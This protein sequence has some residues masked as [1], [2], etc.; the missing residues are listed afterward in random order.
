MTIYRILERPG[1]VYPGAEGDTMTLT[2]MPHVDTTKPLLEAFAAYQASKM[3]S[4]TTIKNRASILRSLRSTVGKPLDQMQLPDLRAFLG[5]PG[6][7]ASSRRTER[8]AI[9]TFYG[10]L[11]DDGYRDD[12]PAIRIAPIKVPRS[13]PRPFS[14]EQIDALLT[15]GAY[16]KTR[17]MI[18]LG[19]HQGFR[20]STIAAVHGHDIDLLAMTIRV[21]VK[22]SKERL[23]PLHTVIAELAQTM[24]RDDWWFPARGGRG[25]H[26]LPASVTERI[27]LAKKRAGIQDPKLTPHS[28]R[29]SFGSDLVENGLDVRVVQELMTHE[30]LSTTQIYTRVSERRKREGLLLLPSHPIPAVSGRKRLEAA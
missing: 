23:L 26:I 13:E 15:T 30:S 9:C 5:R 11:V 17:A 2:S 29:H 14:S 16:R 10:F 6:G 8:N 20:A 19:Y 12:N 22:G 7:K 3:L 21:T 24:P 1:W 18:L 4:P 27:T 28:L 25:G